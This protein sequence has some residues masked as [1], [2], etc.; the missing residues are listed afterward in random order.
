[1]KITVTPEAQALHDSALVLDCHSHFL[2]NGYLR[3]RPFDHHGAS[4]RFFNPLK[5]YLSLNKVRQG[6]IN[7][8]AFTSYA[9]GRPLFWHTDT[10]THKILDRYDAIVAQTPGVTHCTS[11]AQI[12]S[13]VQAGNL[14]LFPAIEGGHVLEGK[15]ENVQAFYDRGV[16]L[17]TLTH[18]VS[19]GIAD[20]AQSPYRPLKGISAFGKEVVAAMQRLGMLVDIAHCSDQAIYQLADMTSGPLV[21]SHSGLRRFKSLKRNLDDRAVRLVA[22][23]KGLFGIILFPNYLGNPDH[24]G[25]SLRSAART[26]RTVANLASPDILCLGSDMDG[27]TWL[28]QG[29]NDASDMPQFTQALMDEGFNASEIRGILGENFLR[30]YP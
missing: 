23:T 7:A 1:M 16:R 18:F 28:P 10:T 12:R 30:V 15:L 20:A 6:G 13:A 29:M 8:L 27:F 4:P 26:A 19:N 25:R 5:N 2:I 21:C 22:E 11:S 9:P 17:L 14:A 3:N 24:V